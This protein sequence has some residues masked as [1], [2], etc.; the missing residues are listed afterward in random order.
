MG[1]I[2]RHRRENAT[3]G[4]N[5]SRI[6]IA[7]IASRLIRVGLVA[8]DRVCLVGGIVAG[9]ASECA[10]CTR[11][12]RLTYLLGIG[13]VMPA[14]GGAVRVIAGTSPGV[15]LRVIRLCDLFVKMRFR[16]A[17]RPGRARLVLWMRAVGVRREAHGMT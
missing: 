12:D 17:V 1:I 11:G 13:V 8:W 9:C 14:V 4:H 5:C 16:L 3:G 7:L 2:V 6:V 10:G 15:L